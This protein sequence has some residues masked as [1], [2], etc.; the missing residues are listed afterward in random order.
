MRRVRPMRVRSAA[1][2]DTACVTTPAGCATCSHRPGPWWRRSPRSSW[3]PCTRCARSRSSA[4]SSRSASMPSRARCWARRSSRS[5]TRTCA[6]GPA[7]SRYLRST[8]PVTVEWVRRY[9]PV[10]VQALAPI[11]PPYVAQARLVRELYP[12]D[13][14][15]VYVSPCYARKDECF[16][17]QFEGAVDVAIDFGELRAL[18]ESAR[19]AEGKKRET[20]GTQGGTRRPA[21]IKELSLTDGFPRDLMSSRSAIDTDVTVI[22]GLRAVDS[23]L[24]SV[25]H[26][27]SGPVIIDMLMCEGCIDGPTVNP[28]MSLSSKRNIEAAERDAQARSVVSSRAL[29]CTTCPTSRPAYAPCGEPI[30]RAQ[31][32]EAE[33][34]PHPARG[35]RWRATIGAAGHAAPLQEQYVEHA[36]ADLPGQ[37]DVGPVLP[38]SAEAARTRS[39][40]SRSMD[41]R[42]LHGAVEPPRVGGASRRRGR[43][44]RPL[45][46]AGLAAHD[47]RRPLRRRAREARRAGRR[48]SARGDREANSS[49]ACA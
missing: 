10:L 13:T 12:P 42:R 29:L 34:R 9:H 15:V 14:A 20:S 37:L 33:D 21:P 48:G 27:E 32:G 19:A 46:D 41:P 23:A 45:R 40:S 17:P 25:E 26:G 31:A 3:P 16:D 8:C 35:F 36:V 24:Y 2:R 1:V 11:V 5:R 44:L 4:S 39:S 43:A 47:R 38:A 28:G 30:D 18:I 22:R 6:S 7:R 49:S